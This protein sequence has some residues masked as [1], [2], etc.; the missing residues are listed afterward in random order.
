MFSFIR[1]IFQHTLIDQLLAIITQHVVF[2]IFAEPTNRKS[3]KKISNSR[4]DVLRR[5]CVQLCGYIECDRILPLVQK[6]LFALRPAERCLLS[7]EVASNEPGDCTNKLSS[8][9]C[10]VGY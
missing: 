2:R 8:N 4:I 5:F 3:E 10:F 6:D 9:A 7:N 1:N